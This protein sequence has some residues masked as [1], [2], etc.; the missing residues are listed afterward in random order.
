MTQ[1]AEYKFYRKTI[2]PVAIKFLMSISSHGALY[3]I[4]YI[5]AI[6]V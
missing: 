6:D 3:E 5:N 1:R 2:L 4:L